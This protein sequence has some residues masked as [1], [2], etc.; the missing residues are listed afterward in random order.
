M[1]DFMIS[2]A[3]VPVGIS[4]IHPG[5]EVFCRDYVTE[6][7]PAFTV[8][9]T[10]EDIA[11]ERGRSARQDEREG[12]A[13]RRFSDAYLETLALYRRLARELLSYDAVVFH[14]SALALD[15]RA[16]LFTAPSG[17]GKTTHTRLWLKN[18]PGCRVLN[19]DK[20]ILRILD[21]RVL[22][23][24]TPWRGKERL[25]S[26]GILPLEA[27]CLLERD[28]ENHIE[29]VSFH[30]AFPALL[31]QTH[32]PE[33]PASMVKILELLGRLREN[34]RLY[35]LGCNM[36]DEAALVSWRGMTEG[37]G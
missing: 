3:G 15:G 1:S 9:M 4:A 28:R 2:L 36:E 23:C 22:A 24:G 33:G 7:Q 17:T 14:G 37:R 8:V 20:P 5:T 21:D 13:P 18:I 35:R 6:E 11:A 25:G 26:G 31:R 16:Y 29:P 30:E 19:G 10:E 34:V 32:H 12:I 27:V